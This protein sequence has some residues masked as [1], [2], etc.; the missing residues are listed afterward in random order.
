MRLDPTTGSFAEWANP[1][2]VRSAP[3][4]M[5]GDDRGRVWQVETGPQPNRFVVFDPATQ[6]F[7]PP[8]PVAQ[9]GG[10]VI[11]HMSFDPQTRSIWFGT[12]AGTIGRG[13]VGRDLT[14]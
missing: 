11:R 4:A 3:Y 13:V 1:A 6:K 9:S 14:P 5:A 8:V 10:L 2:G 7:G 12:D